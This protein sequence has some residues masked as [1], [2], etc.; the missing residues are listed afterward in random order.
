MTI[1]APSQTAQLQQQIQV[2]ER[3]LS[4]CQRLSVLGELVST[5]THE[6]NNVMMT[7]LNYA[8]MGMRSR[9][10]ATRDKALEKILAAAERATRLTNGILGAARNRGDQLAPTD[11]VQL[12]DDSLM[13]LERELNKYRIHVE[14]QFGQLPRVMANGNQIQQIMLNLLTNARQAMPQG[15]TVVVRLSHDPAQQ[16]VELAV[17]DTG[18]GIPES[19]L[20]RIFE[21]FFTTKAGPDATGKG[22]T[23]LGL[24]ACRKIVEAHRGQI[25]VRSSV[26]KGTEFT[27]RLPVGS[28]TTPPVSA[29]ESTSAESISASTTAVT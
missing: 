9:D 12:V 14:R 6:F 29:A 24:S 17:R 23:G 10:E 16:I 28:T 22:G 13:L 4:E 18:C 26:G 20:P 5:T 2:L 19:Q 27:I 25:R 1:D 21:P 8:R 15:G 7:I 3:Q 11:L